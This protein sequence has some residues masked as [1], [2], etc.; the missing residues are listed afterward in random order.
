MISTQHWLCLSVCLSSVF[1]GHTAGSVASWLAEKKTRFHWGVG[2]NHQPQ[3]DP[4]TGAVKQVWHVFTHCCGVNVYLHRKHFSRWHCFLCL[5]EYDGMLLL[6][7]QLSLYLLQTIW[8]CKTHH[9][10]C[11]REVSKRRLSRFWQ[12]CAA[13]LTVLW[14]CAHNDNAHT[15]MFSRYSDYHFSF[16]LAC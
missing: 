4:Q 7:N 2:G 15:L 9:S 10:V 11:G 12:M 8:K 1:W 5:F 14:G 3:E 6:T 16:V 13:M